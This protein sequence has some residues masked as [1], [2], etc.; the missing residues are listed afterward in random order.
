MDMQ[1]YSTLCELFSQY[2]S[3]KIADGREACLL[4]D[5]MDIGRAEDLNC[6]RGKVVLTLFQFLMKMD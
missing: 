4:Y 5:L 1:E 6:L 3:E 2:V